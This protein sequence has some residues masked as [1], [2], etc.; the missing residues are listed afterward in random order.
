MINAWVLRRLLCPIE[1][2]RARGW[3]S[4]HV[5]GFSLF[6]LSMPWLLALCALFMALS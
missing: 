4:D 1:F 5:F 3:V 6:T 2:S